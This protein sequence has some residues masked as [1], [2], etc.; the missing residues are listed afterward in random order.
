MKPSRSCFFLLL[1]AS[2]C[3]FAP[4]T[5]LNAQEQ[6]DLRPSKRDLAELRLSGSDLFVSFPA[7]NNAP[8]FHYFDFDFESSLEPPSGA[9]E[10][11]GI[12]EEIPD[13]YR[14]RY[15]EWKREFLSTEVGRKQ[16]AAYARNTRF[17][18]TINVSRDNEHGAMTG[19][20]KWNDS[21]ELTSVT[22]TLGSELD[23]GYPNPV[24]YPVMNSLGWEG[25]EYLVSGS[26][27]AATKIAHEFGHVN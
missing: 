15:E 10:H 6:S 24:Y 8:D 7:L 25:A 4:G 2:L 23:E 13:K 16:W 5:R 11:G 19:R 20:Y 21:G 9:D 17:T 27:L 3:W 14:D 12:K 26:M 22:I 1:L 18:L